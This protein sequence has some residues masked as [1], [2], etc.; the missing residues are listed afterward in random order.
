MKLIENTD[1]VPEAV[2]TN[3]EVVAKVLNAGLGALGTGGRELVLVVVG[4]VHCK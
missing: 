3:V 2:P 1:D 4:V